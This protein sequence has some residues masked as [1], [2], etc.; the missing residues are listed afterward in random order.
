[1]NGDFPGNITELMGD[2]TGPCG[3]GIVKH[4]KLVESNTPWQ[5]PD[6]GLVSEFPDEREGD[7]ICAFLAFRE[8]LAPNQRYFMRQSMSGVADLVNSAGRDNRAR[9][10]LPP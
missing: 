8:C 2:L 1:M 4:R 6:D 3:S 7:G 10:E 9:L 5:F